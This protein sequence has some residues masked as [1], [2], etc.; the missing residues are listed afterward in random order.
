M[1]YSQNSIDKKRLTAAAAHKHLQTQQ[2]PNTNPTGYSATVAITSQNCI[3]RLTIRVSSC[4]CSGPSGNRRDIIALSGP[5]R[6]CHGLDPV[7]RLIPPPLRIP[8]SRRDSGGNGPRAAAVGCAAG[9]DAATGSICANDSVPP[10]GD[11][12]VCSAAS[13]G[14]PN[15][16]AMYDDRW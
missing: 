15:G 13:V 4:C 11:S 7:A 12:G 2:R 10:S 8:S 6:C 3:N 16:G 1:P 5:R 14:R 9:T